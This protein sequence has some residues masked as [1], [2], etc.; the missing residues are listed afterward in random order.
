MKDEGFREGGKV[1]LRALVRVASYRSWKTERK[2][3]GQVGKDP[4]VE[5]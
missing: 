3:G 1:L 4:A 5:D 2:T